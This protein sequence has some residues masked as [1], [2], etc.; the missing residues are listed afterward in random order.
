[1]A[2]LSTAAVCGSRRV[3]STASVVSS[4]FRVGLTRSGV[5]PAQIRFGSSATGSGGA[6]DTQVA[7]LLQRLREAAESDGGIDPA[8]GADADAVLR[9]DKR[10][11]GPDSSFSF[12]CTAC[13]A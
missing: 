5:A 9:G 2:A 1:M 6:A 10:A 8:V 11:L 12:A 13:G 3:F 7:K 4:I